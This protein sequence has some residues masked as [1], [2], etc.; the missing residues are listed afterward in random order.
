MKGI[1]FVHKSMAELVLLSRLLALYTEAVCKS[2][3]CRS[4]GTVNQ[5]NNR[6]DVQWFC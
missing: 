1:F 2:G 6:W 3:V 4:V 5:Y